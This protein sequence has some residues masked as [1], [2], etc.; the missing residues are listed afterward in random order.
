[1]WQG[2]CLFN[3]REGDRISTMTLTDTL[4]GVLDPG[5]PPAGGSIGVVFTY[6][7]MTGGLVLPASRRVVAR[8]ESVFSGPARRHVQEA[9]IWCWSVRL[10]WKNVSSK[11]RVPFIPKYGGAFVAQ[12][13]AFCHC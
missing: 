1:M 7:M 4:A 5:I 12:L 8:Y 6:A 13:G 10:A 3:V 9:Q 11:T 2:R